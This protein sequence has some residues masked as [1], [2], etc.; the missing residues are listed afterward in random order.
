MQR[1]RW[2][3]PTSSNLQPFTRVRVTRCWSLLGFMV[4][5]AVVYSLKCQS[6]PRSI[7]YL[8]HRS[9]TN[10]AGRKSSAP[11]FAVGR[12]SRAARRKSSQA[13]GAPIELRR[14]GSR[15]HAG[16]VDTVEYARQVLGTEP[17]Y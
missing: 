4:N 13:V 2:E 1:E 3:Q 17:A 15:G 5:F 11:R 7:N 6:L 9:A 12:H 10:P 8:R 14:D 16:K